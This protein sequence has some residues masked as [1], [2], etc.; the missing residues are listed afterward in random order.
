M[1]NAVRKIVIWTLGLPI[2][3]I[4]VCFVTVATILTGIGVFFFKGISILAVLSTGLMVLVKAMPVTIEL[5]PMLLL[6]IALFWIPELMSLPMAGAIALQR[7]V[8][9]LMIE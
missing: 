1:L 2:L 8:W 5:V 3:F 6:S 4:L 7:T 9:D